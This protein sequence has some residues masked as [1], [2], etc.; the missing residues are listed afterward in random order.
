[1]GQSAPAWYILPGFE[2]SFAGH[3]TPF[4]IILMFPLELNTDCHL[5]STLAGRRAGLAGH[6]GSTLESQAGDWGS[7]NE[8][9]R[10][11]GGN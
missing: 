3:L 5:G 2:C 9:W 6:W 10:L 11:P 8:K 1:M 7:I 4:V